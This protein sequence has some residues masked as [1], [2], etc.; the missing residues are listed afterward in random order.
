MGNMK[1][2]FSVMKK[3]SLTILLIGALILTMLPLTGQAEEKVKIVLSI[4]PRGFG[5][6]APE[7]LK[8]FM[9]EHPNIEVEWLK[10]SDVP[11]ESRNFYVTNL[12]AKNSTPDVIAVVEAPERQRLAE[13]TMQVISSVENMIEDLRLLPV[14]NGLGSHDNIEPSHRDKTSRVK[15]EYA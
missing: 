3:R 13:I 9:Q 12:T 10:I 4:G 5:E 15:L 11:N 8:G 1:Q 6:V 2:F 14:R 7:H